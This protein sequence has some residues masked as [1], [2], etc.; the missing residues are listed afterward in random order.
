MTPEPIVDYAC[1]TGENPLFHPEENRIYWTDIPVGKLYRYH[2]ETGQHE[3]CYTG[4]PVGGFTLQADGSLLLFCA[5]GAVKVWR[6]GDIR[7]VVEE[8]PDERETRFNDVIAD[9]EGRVYCGTMPTK[10]RKGRLYRLN[11]DGTL[12]LLL[13]DIGC[14]N[15]MGFSPDGT[16]MYYTD[17]GSRH[18]YLFDY[19]RASGSLTNQR[20]FA[21]VP[22]GE[23]GP[24]GMTVDADGNIWSTRWDGSCL[25]CY[26]PDGAEKTR[27]VVPVKKVSSVVFGGAD[28]ATM[29]ITTAGGNNKETD[30]EHAGA[31]FRLRLPGVH[32]VPEFRSRIGL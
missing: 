6:D 27:I 29:Y 28:Y 31:L 19:N 2:I 10:D 32:G 14:S 16:R 11:T 7:I 12:Y 20:V 26:T 13:E 25:I 23:G 9:P 24:D 1:H 15:G 22:P 3:L 17:T 21:R 5:R 18:I 8:I 4:E 30:G